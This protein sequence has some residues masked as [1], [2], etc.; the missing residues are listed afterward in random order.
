MNFISTSKP[1]SNVLPIL[2]SL[3][4][5][6]VARQVQEDHQEA[7]G[8]FPPGYHDVQDR[9]MEDPERWDGLS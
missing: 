9:S 6:E 3:S 5:V 7:K 4:R 1:A 8:V 2:L